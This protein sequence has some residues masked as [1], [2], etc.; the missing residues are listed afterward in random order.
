MD[1]GQSNALQYNAMEQAKAARYKDSMNTVGS[2]QF[3]Y[4]EEAFINE[5]LRHIESTYKKY[6]YGDDSI[7]VTEYFMSN[8]ET[9]EALKY[10]V[11]QYIMRYGKKEGNNPKDLYKAIHY[12]AMLDYYADRMASKK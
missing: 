8:A 1:L 5:A 9:L 3:K 2:I 12:I 4:D 7:Q 6:H 11:I 10:S